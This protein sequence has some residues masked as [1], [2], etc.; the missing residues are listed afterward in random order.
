MMT[1]DSLAEE[2]AKAFSA[3]RKYKRLTQQNVAASA[4][5]DV[6]VVKRIE[7]ADYD[8]CFALRTNYADAASIERR[9]CDAI[10]LTPRICQALDSGIIF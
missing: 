5:C 1:P 9:L 6:D 3:C 10:G 8:A 2:I 4:G 7:A